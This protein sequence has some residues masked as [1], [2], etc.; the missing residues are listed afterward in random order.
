MDI[1]A[2]SG[3][4]PIRLPAAFILRSMSG[5]QRHDAEQNRLP[6]GK[7]SERNKSS[8]AG[9]IQRLH[10]SSYLS[11][12]SKH[13]ARLDLSAFWAKYGESASCHFGIDGHLAARQQRTAATEQSPHWKARSAAVLS[14]FPIAVPMTRGCHLLVQRSSRF[15]VLQSLL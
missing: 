4:L 3:K 11:M 6:L 15:G 13:Q 9:L 14:R 8:A 2:Q 1:L 12:K 10:P 5:G 7:V